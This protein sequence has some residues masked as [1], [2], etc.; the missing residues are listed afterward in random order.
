MQH[1]LMQLQV[2]MAGQ[3]YTH[4]HTV[5]VNTIPRTRHAPSTIKYQKA[6]VNH[7]LQCL[8]QPFCILRLLP[9]ARNI[10]ITKY[11]HK[12][13]I[14]LINEACMTRPYRCDSYLLC[15]YYAPI[16]VM[17]HPLPR[18]Q[19]DLT[20]LCVNSQCIGARYIV[21]SALCSHPLIGVPHPSVQYMLGTICEYVV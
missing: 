3:G 5:Q 7:I 14:E 8:V 2:L 18:V 19:R 13:L 4:S 12:E 11:F 15:M 9:R 17:P 16:S 10:C 21:K 6:M 1:S 20:N